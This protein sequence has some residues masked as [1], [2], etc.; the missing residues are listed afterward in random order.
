MDWFYLKYLIVPI[1]I[2]AFLPVEFYFIIRNNRRKS[3]L[4]KIS[5]GLKLEINNFDIRTPAMLYG[6][7]IEIALK[8]ECVYFLKENKYIYLNSS[9]FISIKYNN[10]KYI[11]KLA[12]ASKIN[13]KVF[14]IK[15]DDPAFLN[16][17][18]SIATVWEREKHLENDTGKALGTS[19]GRFVLIGVIYV[20]FGVIFALCG[21][22]PYYVILTVL[23]GIGLTVFI[24][25]DYKEKFQNLNRG[26]IEKLVKEMEQRKL[27]YSK[28]IAICL[29]IMVLFTLFVHMM[30]GGTSDNDNDGKCYRCHGA[31]M[32]NNGFLDFDT[33]PAC[34]GTGIP[35]I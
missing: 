34:R 15:C 2:W 3:M 28:I 32:V 21:A 16:Q 29:A 7:P 35:P 13:T 31:G 10:G 25:A 9:D 24:A 6:A 19:I 4:V 12:D 11:F 30:P 8:G 18:S 22:M 17:L 14:V 23:F 1:I 33:C 26:N 5:Q 20:L 27:F